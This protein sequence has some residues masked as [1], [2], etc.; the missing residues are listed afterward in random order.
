MIFWMIVGVRP[1]NLVPP[2]AYKPPRVAQDA[3]ESGRERNGC[4]TRESGRARNGRSKV[5]EVPH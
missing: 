2:S 5:L 3:R 1:R 4:S